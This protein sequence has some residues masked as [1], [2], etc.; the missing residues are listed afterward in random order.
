MARYALIDGYLDTMR[1]EIRWC[2]NLDDLVGEMEDH[3]Y[4]TVEGMLATGTD[5]DAAQRATLDRFGEP[6]FLAALYASTHSGGMAV[7]TTTTIRAGTLAL[8]SAA[9]W[10]I[11][12]GVVSLALFGDRSGDGSDAWHGVYVLLAASVGIAGVLSILVLVALGKR[13]GGFGTPG[14][15]GL[16]LATVGV[17]ISIGITWASPMW[18]GILGIGYLTLGIS[19]YARDIAPKAGS[20]LLSVGML[21]GTAAFF[22]VEAAELGWTDSEGNYPLAWIIS[23]MTGFILTGLA[24]L[25]L[26]LWLRSESPV[27][28]HR[29]PVAA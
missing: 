27:E 5:P 1:S 16:V 3:L 8:T 14:M 23:E 9:F 7:P 6:K 20:V 15:V 4:S 10:L 24:L 12:A 29:T 17:V 11:S 25:I 19:M 28:E 21:I 26:G 2:S 18:M 13:H 22:I